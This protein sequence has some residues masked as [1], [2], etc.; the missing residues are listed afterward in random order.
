VHPWRDRLSRWFTP[1]ARRSPLSPNAV[2]ILALVLNLLAAFLLV[3]ALFLWAIVLVA[4]GGLADAFDGIVARAQ[5]KESRFGDFLD[6]FAD[7]LSD[8]VLAACWLIGSQVRESLV[9]AA[10]IAVMLNGY[11]GT[12]IEATFQE[13][14][15][16]SLGRGEFVLGLIVLPIISY[17]LLHNGWSSLAF[18]GITITEWLAILLIAFALLGIVQRFAVARRLERS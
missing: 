11:L 9:I 10:V 18:A 4:A 13:R 3:R 12:Q 5:G 7:R 1:L 2:T 15:Y 16:D 8:T 17:I 14:N 6:H